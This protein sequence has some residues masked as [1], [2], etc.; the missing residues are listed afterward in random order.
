MLRTIKMRKCNVRNVQVDDAVIRRVSSLSR[1]LFVNLIGKPQFVSGSILL[2][3]TSDLSKKLP[4][5]GK[6]CMRKMQEFYKLKSK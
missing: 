5:C 3:K 2:K 1:H 4:F 6:A